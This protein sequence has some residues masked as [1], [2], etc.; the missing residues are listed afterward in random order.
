LSSAFLL[1]RSG[2]RSPWLAYVGSYSFAIYLLHVIFTAGSR[3]FFTQL[4]LTNTYALLLLGTPLGIVG[5]LAAGKFY[6][7]EI[8]AYAHSA[9]RCRC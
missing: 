4:H 1:L 2:W 6:Q 5:P 3:I 9:Q 7:G 8:F